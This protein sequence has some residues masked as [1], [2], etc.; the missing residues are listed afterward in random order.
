MNQQL[1]N[2]PVT[3]AKISS[4]MNFTLLKIIS[5]NYVGPKSDINIL[6]QDNSEY[7]KVETPRLL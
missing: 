7:S 6:I 1:E 3:H 5:H 2:Y 4:L